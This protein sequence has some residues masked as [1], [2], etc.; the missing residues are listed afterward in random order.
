M[1]ILSQHVYTRVAF[2]LML[3]VLGVFLPRL[4]NQE[5]DAYEKLPSL[6]GDGVVD[7]SLFDD[8]YFCSEKRAINC[9]FYCK[10]ETLTCEDYASKSMPGYTKASCGERSE[11]CFD[12]CRTRFCY[13]VY[14]AP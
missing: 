7:V 1:K 2:V 11:E 3:V 12:L 6:I 8:P 10:R 5:M 14:P 13:I 9:H 4:L